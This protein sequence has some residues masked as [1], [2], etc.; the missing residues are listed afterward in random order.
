MDDS[1]LNDKFPS[2]DRSLWRPGEDVDPRVLATSAVF[3]EA[4]AEQ[5]A[6]NTNITVIG[7]GAA[8]QAVTRPFGERYPDQFVAL[9]GQSPEAARR[10]VE[11]AE[12]GDTVYLAVADSNSVAAIWPFLRDKVCRRRLNVKVV[13][14]GSGIS[15]GEDLPSPEMVE[16]L[17][18]VRVLPRMTV[19]V[20]A[21][22]EE[23]K[24][25]LRWS[26]ETRGPAYIRLSTFPTRGVTK[27]YDHFETGRAGLLNPGWDLTMI[28]CG[29]LVSL[30][31]DTAE[32]LELDRI[33][34]RVLNFS[35][36]KPIDRTS[37]VEA[38]ID[39]RRIITIEEHQITGGLG[40][41]VAE[42]IAQEGCGGRV[43]MIGLHNEFLADMPTKD[44]LRHY[45]LTLGRL[46]GIA[47]ELIASVP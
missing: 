44:L 32:E 1:F 2:R 12:K 22:A 23:T 21:D 9:D 25:V 10:A 36:I 31:L 38:A 11:A 7:R 18:L 39:T 8:V 24:R 28:A 29:P 35:T 19:V 3:G 20:P 43:R 17:A 6:R 46:V 33:S 15:A 42:I 34:A 40:S 13:A 30:A 26:L 4:L 41:A 5:V 37:I 45:G 27:R 14:A 47:K 16:D